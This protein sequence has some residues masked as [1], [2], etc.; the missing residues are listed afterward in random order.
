MQKK[1]ISRMIIAVT[2]AGMMAFSSLAGAHAHLQSSLPAAKAQVT[3]SPDALTLNFS[4]DIEAAFSGVTLLD[5]AQKPVVT[6]KARVESD[7]KKR[8]IVGLPQPLKAGSYQVNWH[9]L[10]VDGHKTAGSY[11]FSVK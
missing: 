9:V 4:E 11:R 1:T 3:T 10:S 8:L 5:S 2:A 7:Q 6:A